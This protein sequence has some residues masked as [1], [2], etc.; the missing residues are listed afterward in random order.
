M[1]GVKRRLFLGSALA[2]T[3]PA[4]AAAASPPGG[5]SA[6]EPHSAFDQHTFDG[7]VARPARIRQI[8]ENVALKPGVLGNI[9]NSLN[10]L[11]F[12][13]AYAPNE[14]A[15]A[16]VNHGPSAAYTYGDVL[17]EKYRIADYVGYNKPVAD[18]NPLRV[19]ATKVEGLFGRG[20]AQAAPVTKN[21]FYHRK[22]KPAASDPPDDEDSAYQDASIQALQ[23][24]GVVFLTCH[25][26]VMEQS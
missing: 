10:G 23:S 26:A 18:E 2:G 7:A 3:L 1:G 8:W 6:V 22:S 20:D 13:Y 16:V 17:W 19:A 9:K 14:I 21:P 24:R 11:Q 5:L 15:S 25:T 12:G 4:Y